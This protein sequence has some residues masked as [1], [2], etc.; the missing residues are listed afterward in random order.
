LELPEQPHVLDGDHGLV[1]EG[2]QELNLLV[3][4]GTNLLASNQD[5][6]D[7]VAL[8]KQRHGKHGSMAEAVL[9]GLA[10]RKFGGGLCR[11]VVKMDG[12]A[13]GNRSARRR[14]AIEG[15]PFVEPRERPMVSH[16]PQDVALDE[17][18]ER[19]I[20]PADARSIL[21]DRVE[22]GL[23]IRERT[24]DYAQDL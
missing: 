16:E 24:R 20:C 2:L 9:E 4:K 10:N 12:L 15:D 13:V 6:P 1:G 5:P 14:A 22:H 11:E 23:D 3:G 8:S 17:A 19:V 18:D 21:S 7:G